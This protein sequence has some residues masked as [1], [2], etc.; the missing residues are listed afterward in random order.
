M[1]AGMGREPDPPRLL[2]RDAQPPST[3]WGFVRI[4]YQSR[5]GPV[6]RPFGAS[7]LV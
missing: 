3:V 4:D 2:S 1:Q 7:S 5:L 6:I